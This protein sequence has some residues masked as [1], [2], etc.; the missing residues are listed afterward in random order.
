MLAVAGGRAGA[1]SGM[2]VLVSGDAEEVLA[3]WDDALTLMLAAEDLDGMAT[4]L[5][6]V[7]GPVKM[8]A[9]F[10]AYVAAAG[11]GTHR[12]GPAY[13][14]GDPEHDQRFPQGLAEYPGKQRAVFNLVIHLSYPLS[15]RLS[16]RH[17]CGAGFCR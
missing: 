13:A 10:E 14:G 2:D 1:G 9:L 5:Y 16:G 11:S 17:T 4:A 3:A 12:P 6:T 15:S 7:G 8:D